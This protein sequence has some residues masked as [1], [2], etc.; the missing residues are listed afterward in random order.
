[1]T[2]TET[3]KA[4]IQKAGLNDKDSDYEG[5]IGEA[6]GELLDVFQ[7]QGHSGFSAIMV[8][9]IFKSLIFTG[10]ESLSVAETVGDGITTT[11]QAIVDFMNETWPE[12]MDSPVF[13]A[14]GCANIEKF[15]RKIGVKVVSNG[16]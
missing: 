1:M 2:V 7:K 16:E 12:K 10:G 14:V 11:K 5:M 4:T 13:I 15:I 8:A 9:D 6:L 3:A